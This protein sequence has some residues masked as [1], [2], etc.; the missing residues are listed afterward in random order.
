MILI[1]T[2]KEIEI[3]NGGGIFPKLPGWIDKA[4]L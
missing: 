2:H 1:F 4:G 3:Y